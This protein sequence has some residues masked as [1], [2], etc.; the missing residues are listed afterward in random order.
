MIW[1]VVVDLKQILLVGKNYDWP[2][3]KTCPRCGHWRVWGHGYALRYFDDFPMALP[4]KCYRCPQCGCVATARPTDYFSRIRSRMT[5]ILACLS[6]RL[7]QGRWPVLPLP[8]SRL[9]H[10]LANLGRQVQ[11]YL[12]NTWSE[13][14]LA[15][16]DALL[17]RGLIPITRVS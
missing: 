6:Q 8:R 12:T 13:G 4:M 16:Y 9:R 1:S 2:R 7:T 3:P 11:I 17:E 10:W 5:I 14:L 15:G